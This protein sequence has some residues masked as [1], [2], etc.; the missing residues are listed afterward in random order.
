MED[1]ISVERCSLRLVAEAMAEE[2]H[3]D[4]GVGV[5]AMVYRFCPR[6]TLSVG[7][8]ED[9]SEEFWWVSAVMTAAEAPQAVEERAAAVQVLVVEPVASWASAVLKRPGVPLQRRRT[10]QRGVLSG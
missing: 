2:H 1:Q 9:Q 8:E 5:L 4:S 10:E 7:V 3:I 6:P